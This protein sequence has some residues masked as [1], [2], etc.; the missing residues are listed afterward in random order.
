MEASKVDSFINNSYLSNMTLPLPTRGQLERSLSQRVQA[1]YRT[2]LGQQ[3]SKVQCSISDGKVFLVLE[4]SITKPEQVLLQQ[5]QTKLAEQVRDDLSKAWSEQLR[6]A[7]KEI[8]GISVVDMMTDAT[9]ET[10]RV[11][12]IAVLAEA[13]QYRESGRRSKD[14]DMPSNGDE[15]D[16]PDR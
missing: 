1:L 14:D 5:G 9:L 12:T 10:G 15:S 16:S 3:P 7:I 6:D 13:P 11:G 8:T 2:Q 4:D